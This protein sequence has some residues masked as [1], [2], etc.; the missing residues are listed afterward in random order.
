MC[1]TAG[2][3]YGK[4]EDIESLNIDEDTAVLSKNVPDIIMIMKMGLFIA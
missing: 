1:F 2:K 3:G 4:S